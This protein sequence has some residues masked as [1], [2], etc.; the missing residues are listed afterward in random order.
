[1]IRLWP[2]SLFG[3][4]VI[5]LVTGL[6]VAQLVGIIIHWRD[7]GQALF[8]FGGVQLAH[9]IVEVVELLEPLSERERLR[10]ARRLSGPRLSVRL[11]RQY[12][13]V[14]EGYGYGAAFSRLIETILHR[15]LG[16][17]RPLQVRVY[18]RPPTPDYVMHDRPRM[19]NRERFSE[20]DTGANPVY[21]VT[22]LRLSDGTGAEFTFRLP[23]ESVSWP[24]RLL[25][26][27]SVLIASVIVL[28]LI[29]V[30]L[31]TRPL[32]TL[33][34]AATE[35][36]QDINRPPLPETGPREVRHAAHAFN[37]M[38][39]QIKQFVEQRTNLLA[40]V[41]HDL[42]TPIT[43]LRI[44]AELLDDEQL[45]EKFESDLTEME[46]MVNETLEFMRGLDAREPLQDIDLIALLESIQAD[47]DQRGREVVLHRSA[48]LT[49]RGRPL[50]LKRCLNNLVDNALK[51]ATRAEITVDG[52]PDQIVVCI[53]DD[54]PGIPENELQ[55]V[56]EPFYRVDKSR[57]RESGGTGMGLA[58]ARAIARNHGGD[59][60][61]RNRPGGGL[62]A[63]LTL[64]VDTTRRGRR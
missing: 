18:E 48:P 21:V 16:E 43:R 56:F 29:A 50:A 8:R 6:I 32:S 24:T 2:Q 49:Y 9:R 52:G 20:E 25:V 37:A 62:E 54:G 27:I 38:Q 17:A 28:A 36:G 53:A 61:L 11:Q 4:L 59:L 58:I 44:R 39:S 23:R 60:L 19:P 1:M 55:R 14:S 5:I 35:L 45:K 22:Q 46:Q 42:K 40:A 33:A 10:I 15:H 34:K 12:T 26:S 31:T 13:P 41:S 51:Y 57:S 63:I 47:A 30:R 3:R 7:R 64:G